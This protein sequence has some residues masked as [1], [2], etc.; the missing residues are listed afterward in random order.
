MSKQHYMLN[1]SFEIWAFSIMIKLIIYVIGNKSLL[2][3]LKWCLN[4]EQYVNTW[5]KGDERRTSPPP[6]RPHFINPPLRI[7]TA[8]PSPPLSWPKVYTFSAKMEKKVTK[9][10]AKSPKILFKNAQLRIFGDFAH[11]WLFFGHF[12][13]IFL[14]F[15][16]PAPPSHFELIPPSPIHSTLCTCMVWHHM[17]L[18][19]TLLNIRSWK[20]CGCN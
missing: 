18:S 7:L 10:C 3:F 8:L 14:L 15:A 1:L 2:K 6:P 9:K 13:V 5:A 16:P 20:R 17:V 12:L 19:K 11:F 4:K